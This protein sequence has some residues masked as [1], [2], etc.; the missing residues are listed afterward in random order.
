MAI[1]MLYHHTLEGVSGTTMK[2]F[3]TTVDSALATPWLIAGALFVAGGFTFLRVRKAFKQVWGEV[4]TEIE[5]IVR[6][7]A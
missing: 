3:G 5:E 1:E 4:N 2:L 6:R 7:G